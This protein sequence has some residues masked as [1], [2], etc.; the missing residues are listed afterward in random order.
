MVGTVASQQE[1]HGL[2]SRCEYEMKDSECELVLAL[3]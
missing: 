2:D 3:P 1:G